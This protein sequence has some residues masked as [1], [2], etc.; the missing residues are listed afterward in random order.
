MTALLVIIITTN[1]K[2]TTIDNTASP[3]L[4]TETNF[5]KFIESKHMKILL[6]NLID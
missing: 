1:A 4:K 5:N 6:S 2:E 3:D